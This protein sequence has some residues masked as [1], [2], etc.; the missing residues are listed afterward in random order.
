MHGAFSYLHPFPSLFLSL[1]PPF[2]RAEL[3]IVLIQC[4]SFLKFKIIY[5]LGTRSKNWRYLLIFLS[6][7]F[8]LS[9]IALVLLKNGYSHRRRACSFFILVKFLLS[10]EF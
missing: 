9:M 2:N 7:Y 10:S 4:N 3:L 5:R 1:E 6:L 8:L